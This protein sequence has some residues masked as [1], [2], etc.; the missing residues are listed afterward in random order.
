MYFENNVNNN[1]TK[2][3]IKSNPYPNGANFY[4][5]QYVYNNKAPEYVPV[6]QAQYV[7]TSPRQAY[8]NNF[9][10]QNRAT[11]Q[12]QSPVFSQ[13]INQFQAQ[14]PAYYSQQQLQIQ[15][16]PYPNGATPQ[17][18]PF[19]QTRFFVSNESLAREEFINKEMERIEIEAEIEAEQKMKQNEDEG[20]TKT[21]TLISEIKDL[22]EIIQKQNSII[23]NLRSEKVNRLNQRMVIH[24]R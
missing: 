8:Q 22:M 19:V 1:L 18:P 5:N 9:Y 20:K 16:F 6:A 2:Q 24:N 15:S 23:K 11:Y 7:Q 21:K 14:N 10:P 17:V 3:A 4:P 12:Q 13:P